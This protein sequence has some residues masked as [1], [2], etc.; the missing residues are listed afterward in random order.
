MVNIH[1]FRTFLFD[2]ETYDVDGV[3]LLDS[4]SDY[5]II[6]ANTI[7]TKQIIAFGNGNAKTILDIS[8]TAVQAIPAG[9]AQYKASDIQGRIELIFLTTSWTNNLGTSLNNGDYLTC[10]AISGIVGSISI[11]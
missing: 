6:T 8:F 5:L 9:G 3:R 10:K 2:I 11:V 7:F 1:C 4:Y